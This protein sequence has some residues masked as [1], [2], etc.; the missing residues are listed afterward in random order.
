L[1]LAHMSVRKQFCLAAAIL[2][3]LA[4]AAPAAAQ[5]PTSFEARAEFLLRKM[6]SGLLPTPMLVAMLR[7]PFPETRVLAVRV[8]ASSGDPSQTLLL[9]EYLGDQDFRVR[10]QVMVA[11]GRLGHE[12]K[13]LALKGLGDMIPK[14]RQAAAWAACHGG[15]DAL[16]PLVKAMGRETDVGV[17]ATALANLWRFDEAGWEPYAA[18]AAAAAGADV[19]LRRAAAYSLSRSP[20][21]EARAALRSL[22]ADTEA[23]IRATAIAGLRRAALAKDDF[24]VIERALTDPDA[25]VRAAA[26]G[27]LAEQA[28]PVLPEASA[29]VVEAMWTVME[30]HTAVMALRAAGARPEIGSDSALLELVLSEEPWLASEAFA[31][32]VVRGGD[33]DEIA[34]EWL[35]CSEL[36][37]R[38]A[39]AAA[40]SAMGGVGE[41]AVVKEPEPA[42][43]L[44]WLE[45]LEPEDV[46]SRI[47][48]LRKLVAEDP[49]PFVRTAALNHLSDAVLA[50]SFAEL[51][52]LAQSWVSD[53][54][55]DARAAALTNALAVASNDEQRT[56]VLE[57]SSND[58]DP[59][60]AI[61]L[62]NAARSAGLP[63]RST[64]RELR[65]NRRWY[66]ELVEWMRGR[67][68]LDV[69]TDRG[70]FRIRLDAIDA[71]ISVREIFDLA[72]SG[73]YDDLVIHRVVPNFVVQ[74]GDPR[75]D[76]WGGPGFILPDEPAF[77]P[78]DAWR[79][80]IATSGPNTGGS[81]LFITL[82]PA[83][84]LVGHY[85]NLGEV[86]AGR[87]V[88]AR[89]R[90]GDRIRGI[91]AFSGDEP[92][93]PTPVLL[94]PIEWDALAD[95]PG[96][97]DEYHE[98]EPGQASIETLASAAGSY[99]IVTVLGSWCHDSQREVP[100]LI[101]VL[102]QLDAPVF[103]HEMIGVDR[104]RRIDD[105]ELAIF[106]GV[107]RTVDRVATIVVFDADGIELGRVV[108]TAEKPI[109]EILVEFLAPVEGWEL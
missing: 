91:E 57:E 46:S 20:R 48:L 38:K 92:P 1:I 95:L 75:G 63:A 66:V 42:V 27:V 54:V 59:A 49:D 10:Y 18:A 102:D 100:R 36:W 44:A 12:G 97:Q 84:H 32:L 74:G 71:P 9:W 68:W 2:V 51:I 70:G 107:E 26:C 30:P 6:D 53:E 19:Q 108:E 22:A 89:L 4:I 23:V 104:T 7:D 31:A 94:G 39:V 90:V 73:F 98:A 83:D 103:E 60:V 58:R 34:G 43:R 15:D 5:D 81:Q 88:V 41:K 11:A 50:G 17:R 77:S 106:A 56:R 87:E 85:T 16:A 13:N 45:Q 55:P 37:Q 101:K 62:I 21:P 76:G 86:I 64:E 99:R 96:W 82:M 109:E 61:L 24:M 28:E 35:S 93:P 33:V 67:H 80:G 25:R 65:H 78:F 47:A 79:V 14:V 3:G 105:A 8:V 52:D 69:T 29:S 72:A 40:A